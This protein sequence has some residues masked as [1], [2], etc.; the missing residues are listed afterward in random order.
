MTI[1]EAQAEIRR[2]EGALQRAQAE[3]L[4]YRCRA[5]IE[6][7]KIAM[8]VQYGWPITLSAAREYR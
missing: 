6:R 1:E 7:S 2:L 5:V 3:A 4:H 8:H